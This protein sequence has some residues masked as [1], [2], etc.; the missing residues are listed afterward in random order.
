[1]LFGEIQPFWRIIS[2]LSSGS[3]SKPNKKP[4]EA[5]G[6]LDPEDGGE[7][8]PKHWT[9]SKLHGLTAQNTVLFTVAAM[10][11]SNPTKEQLTSK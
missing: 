1:M 4:E 7:I 11:T 9:S 5:G 6:Y 8:S 10:R 2:P 3:K